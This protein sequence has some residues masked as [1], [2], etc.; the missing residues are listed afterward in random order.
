MKGF[1]SQNR[2]R[3]HQERRSSLPKKI[4]NQGKNPWGNLAQDW[5]SVTQ[6]PKSKLMQIYFLAR[7]VF[8]ARW[9]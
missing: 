3:R 2:K 6:K 9:K 4:E 8:D 7:H 1:I 5:S